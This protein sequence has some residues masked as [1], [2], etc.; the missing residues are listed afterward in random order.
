MSDA[1]SGVM[2]VLRLLIPLSLLVGRTLLLERK[3][4]HKLHS[5]RE[6]GLI[7]ILML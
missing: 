4:L 2:F 6:R 3:K 5:E 7:M 1:V